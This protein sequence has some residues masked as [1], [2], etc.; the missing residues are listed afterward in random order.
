MSAKELV[1]DFLNLMFI[2]LLVAFCIV[3]F[4][5][6]N[7]FFAFSLF[8]QSM[9][10]LAFFGVIFLVRLKLTR[11]EIKKRKKHGN[12]ELVLYLNIFHKL[13]SDVVVFC[14]PIL[15]GLLIYKARGFIDTIDV[16][17][18]IAVFLIMF[19]WQRYIF[20]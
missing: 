17:I 14:S 13:I 9:V 7:H 3:Y 20:S 11:S 16:I 8:L 2:L 15:L 12:T 10:P 5:A 18:L 1:L 4:I 19:F 6:G